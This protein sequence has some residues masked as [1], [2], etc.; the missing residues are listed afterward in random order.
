V[1]CPDRAKLQLLLDEQLP[2]RDLDETEG[3]VEHC[4]ICQ[5]KLQWLLTGAEGPEPAL[6]QQD[7]YRI[8]HLHAQGG[9]GEVFVAQDVELNRQVALK[10]MQERYQKDPD[11]RRRFLQETEI[12][13]RLE[14]PGVVPVYGLV[15]D[16]GGNPCYAMRFIRGES[17]EDAIHRFHDADKPGRD[18]GERSLALRHL[19]SRFV[20]ICNAVGYAHSRG[21]L[22]RDLKP[23]NVMLG[24]YGET[25]VVDWGLAKPIA[26]DDSARAGGE[27]T[28]TPASASGDSATRIGEAMGT[29]SYMSPEQARGQWEQVGPAS[30]IYSLGTI[31]YALLTGKPPFAAADVREKLERVK[32]GDF[33]RPGAVKP[34]PPAL[35]AVCVKAMALQ[36]Q[37][38]Y[39]TALELAADV[40]HWL[41]DEPVQA[42]PEPWTRRVR[43]WVQRH[44]TLATATGTALLLLIVGSGVLYR[45]A[46][47]HRH[48]EEQRTA[49]LVDQALGEATAL[50]NE[51]RTISSGDPAQQKREAFLWDEA[52]AAARRTQEALASGVADAATRS[53]AR[54]FVAELSAEA[55]DAKKD[56]FMLQRLEAARE[57]SQLFNDSDY[58]RL[59]GLRWIVWGTGGGKAYAAAFKDY[60][61]DVETLHWQD[62][63]E[64][65]RKCRRISMELCAALDDWYFN[66][67]EAARGRLLDISRKA[68]PDP[69]RSQVRLAIA[70]NDREKLKKLSAD[71]NIVDLPARTIILLADVLY[72]AGLRAEAVG[73][74]E[75]GKRAYPQDFWV[76]E[77]LGLYL[78]DG[79]PPDYSEAGRCFAAALA[80]R[81]NS[82]AVLTSLGHVLILEGQLD[83][84]AAV[85]RKSIDENPKLTIGYD[86]LSSAVN[87]KG[88]LQQAI[89]VIQDGLKQQ[90]ES[91][92]LLTDLGL[93]LRDQGKDEEA[94][95]AFQKALKHES[96]WLQAQVGLA[97]VLSAIEQ[98]DQALEL[99]DKAQRMHAK[100]P[101]LYHVYLE[102]G[103]IRRYAGDLEGARRR[104]RK[105]VDAGPWDPETLFTWGLESAMIP[106]H[107]VAPTLGHSDQ[108][109]LTHLIAQPLQ[110]QAAASVGGPTASLLHA[111]IVA[112]VAEP[113]MSALTARGDLEKVLQAQRRFIQLAPR[114][115]VFRRGLAATLHALGRF[116]EATATLREAIQLGLDAHIGLG[117]ML[118]L[119]QK[120]SE[121]EGVCREAIKLHS[122]MAEAHALLGTALL[123]QRKFKEA[124][125]SLKRAIE[126]NPNQ[127]H[128]HNELGNTYFE[129]GLFREAV[130]HCMKASSMSP[131]VGLYLGNVG[132]ALRCAGDFPEAIKKLRRAAKLDPTSS[133]I[134][135]NL[136]LAFI[137]SGKYEE[138]IRAAQEAIR[139][140][141][142]N[143]QAHNALAVALEQNGNVAEAIPEYQEATV[144]APNEASFHSDLGDAL[145]RK[146]SPSQA[147]ESYREAARLAP[148]NANYHAQVAETL[149]I[150]GQYQQAEDAA[151]KALGI[152]SDSIRGH[153]A[154]ASAYSYQA[155]YAEAIRHHEEVIRLSPKSA[156]SYHNL[157]DTR[158]VMNDV[159]GAIANYEKALQIDAKCAP[160]LSGLSVLY[161][162]QGKVD[163]ALRLVKK[164]LE[165]TGRR[166]GNGQSEFSY[167]LGVVG[168][169]L[170]NKGKYAEAESICRE[171][172]AAA[173]KQHPDSL[174]TFIAKSIL[175]RS[176]LGQKKYD[177]AEQLLLDGH[178][179]IKQRE[180]ELVSGL[181]ILGGSRPRLFEV[182][183]AL[184][185]L[186]DAVAKK[187]EAARWRKER[188]EAKGYRYHA[189]CSALFAAE[190]RGLQ[191]PRSQ[192]KVKLRAQALALLREEF[193]DFAKQAKASPVEA[194]HELLSETTIWKQDPRLAKV[195]EPSQLAGLPGEEQAAWRRLWADLDQ[196][197]IQASASAASTTI[198]IK[199]V[200]TTQMPTQ[201]YELKLTAGT[202]YVI[203]LRSTA[204]NGH[205]KVLNDK[206]V[207]RAENKGLLVFT[208]AWNET[209]TFQVVASSVDQRGAGPFTLTIWALQ[210]ARKWEGLHLGHRSSRRDLAAMRQSGHGALRSADILASQALDGIAG[211]V[212]A[213]DPV[214]IK[215]IGAVG[216]APVAVT[217]IEHPGIAAVQ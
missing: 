188:A 179:G 204:F 161:S 122:D 75:R 73:L 24:R 28:L 40:E 144:W 101:D 36:A 76:H 109:R 136:A 54:T 185:E 162:S 206:Q 37:Q 16:A 84:A 127:S 214:A 96:R 79:D 166:H 158:A 110:A 128:F 15:Q 13:A 7:R 20:A 167:A 210:A 105:A 94:I 213:V 55:E 89:A 99:L 150:L 129:Q 48:D 9:L 156:L 108:I 137:N 31:L 165:V 140:E 111:I 155:R 18:T 151:G 86:L 8:V 177:Q 65:I 195:R 148:T 41:A 152:D 30:D 51:A 197:A 72:Q 189:A 143:G 190:G 163:A 121:A 21:I 45:L 120:H 25:L 176:L 19:L 138:A 64:R 180:A 47:M 116:D 66:A 192:D 184:V 134:Q 5:A 130:T 193:N 187:G 181:D 106:S 62:A 58:V 74:L 139:L 217:G 114:N 44:R 43:R 88:E 208:P 6:G 205:L 200:L 100:N 63:A 82:A 80:L 102:Q 56:L 119:Q 146:G 154:L 91:P 170:L 53:R 69:L 209:G 149:V 112:N 70:E 90:P 117:E 131:R 60:G 3:H 142:A 1:T 12:T 135:T 169:N 191:Q 147:V 77:H 93:L 52:L 173:A 141:P 196:V 194:V 83:A 95:N 23:G 186:Y 113:H 32:R 57:K 38:R 46:Q 153:N 199:G 216:N 198:T 115:L 133:L 145:L 104:Y 132:E 164:W 178:E 175:G 10:R 50:R 159:E 59:N 97:R 168:L 211:P 172:H 171:Y 157:A 174:I 61:I 81:P 2:V 87:A 124:A 201:A 85:L 17:L 212:R 68:D 207:L 39:P 98:H 160:A 34:C 182:L 107:G 22:H 118:I 71:K 14:H 42:W 67:P 215:L 33:L 103:Q 29:P 35:E 92:M 125:A 4:P 49:L 126:I 27:A 202:T 123:R 183:D 11:S 203:D 78:M 26:R